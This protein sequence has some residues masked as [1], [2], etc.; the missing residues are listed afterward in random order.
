MRQFALLAVVAVALSACALKSDVRRVE[1][2]L[3]E[4]Q[5]ETAR[6]DSVRAVVLDLIVTLQE[7]IADSL[8]T[9]DRQLTS[10]QGDVRTDMTEV[11]RQLVQIQELTG[12]SQ[13][14]L[15][16]LRG[17][18]D[19][20]LVEARSQPREGQPQDT[21]GGGG[22]AA[23]ELYDLSLQQLRRGSPETARAG[24]RKFLGDFPEHPLAADARFFLGESWGE[25][26]PDSAAAAYEQVVRRDPDSRRAPTALY[27][28]G[29]LAERR[30]DQ[31]A[32]E[33]YYSR[34]IAGYPRSEEAQL[35]RTKLGNPDR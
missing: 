31:R 16:D 34:V 19:T 9:L 3:I 8:G 14:R 35:A 11:Q 32:A 10:F 30:G 23:Q 5:A 21:L 1:E 12:Q 20:R 17:Q 4:M 15:S 28:L 7:Q 27:R 24:F 33:V 13:Q 29:L 18:L 6:T 26:Y 22:I 2:R 25:G